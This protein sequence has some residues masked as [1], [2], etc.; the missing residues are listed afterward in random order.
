MVPPPSAPRTTPILG[1]PI[2]VSLR[3]NGTVQRP[4]AAIQTL[5]SWGLGL[6]RAHDLLTRLADGE[7][8]PSVRLPSAPKLGVMIETLQGFGIAVDAARNPA[9][10]SAVLTTRS[11]PCQSGPAS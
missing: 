9:P 5:G 2:E 1:A 4:M 6:R 3:L 11:G 10:V 8:L 7:S